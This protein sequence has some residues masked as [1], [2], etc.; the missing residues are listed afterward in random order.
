MNELEVKITDVQ[1]RIFGSISFHKTIGHAF[2]DHFENFAFLQNESVFIN[3]F[4]DSL[5]LFIQNSKKIR[6]PGMDLIL[7]IYDFWMRSFRDFVNEIW[8]HSEKFA[9]NFFKKQKKDGKDTFS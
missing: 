3:N 1:K 5:K 8:K 2:Y 4:S 7:A 6:G 9:L